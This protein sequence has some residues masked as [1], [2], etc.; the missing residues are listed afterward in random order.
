MK[1]NKITDPHVAD[2]DYES[3]VKGLT[4]DGS[5]P[6]DLLRSDLIVRAS[7]IDMTP[8]KIPPVDHFYD[9]SIVRAVNAELDAAHWTPAP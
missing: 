3:A 2:F 4:K 9:Y 7:L 5:V 6:D 1:Y 8:D